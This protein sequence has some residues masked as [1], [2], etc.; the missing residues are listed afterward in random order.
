MNKP[1]RTP[2]RPLSQL[3]HKTLSEAFAKQGF[4]SSELVTRWTEIVGADIAEHCEPEKIQWSRRVDGGLPQPGKLMLRVEGPVAVEIQHLSNVI[5]KRVN[6]FFGWRAA[7]AIRIRQ[8]PLRRAVREIPAPPDPQAME[9]IRAG[10]G[11][12]QNDDL[13]DALARLGV[14]IK[15]S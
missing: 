12:I 7:D 2:P 8:A 1:R 9:R 13:R 3:L 5:L 10:L 4:A 14:A 6:S 15:Q 11:D